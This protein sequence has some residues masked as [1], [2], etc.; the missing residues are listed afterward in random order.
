MVAAVAGAAAV[1]VLVSLVWS[2]FPPRG[3]LAAAPP[4]SP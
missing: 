4:P 3:L 2:V 1:V